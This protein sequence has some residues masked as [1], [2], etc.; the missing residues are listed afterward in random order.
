MSS[1]RITKVTTKNYKRVLTHRYTE[2]PVTIVLEAMR[3]A[4]LELLKRR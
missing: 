1:L 4:I 3:V 2:R